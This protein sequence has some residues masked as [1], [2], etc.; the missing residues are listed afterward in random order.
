MPKEGKARIGGDAGQFA[1]LGYVVKG[2]GAF[3][4]VLSLRW[5]SRSLAERAR[6]QLALVRGEV[7]IYTAGVGC[8]AL[9]ARSPST[10][11]GK[12]GS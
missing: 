7:P 11:S 12:G 1:G 3:P 10:V 6:A 2:G 9:F 8:H 4:M 5:A